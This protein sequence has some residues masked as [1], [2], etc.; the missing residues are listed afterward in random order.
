MENIVPHR[1]KELIH[2]PI[3]IF[4]RILELLLFSMNVEY[5]ENCYLEPQPNE[6]RSF[7]TKNNIYLCA[8]MHI[9]IIQFPCIINRRADTRTATDM[10]IYIYAQLQ[11]VFA[12]VIAQ[13]LNRQPYSIL[14]ALNSVD[15]N[16]SSFLPIHSQFYWMLTRLNIHFQYIFMEKDESLHWGPWHFHSIYELCCALMITHIKKECI[17]DREI[18]KSCMWEILHNDCQACSFSTNY[19]NNTIFLSGRKK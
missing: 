16:Q 2:R 17:I 18:Y 3:F 15:R 8:V 6:W 9:W 7:K 13:M 19:Q 11:P 4:L 5:F 1:Q 12:V 14:R 10:H